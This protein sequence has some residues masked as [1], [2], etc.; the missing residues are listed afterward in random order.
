MS[1]WLVS[2]E[3]ISII[4]TWTI[5]NNLEAL[6]NKSP[7]QWFELLYNENVRSLKARYSNPQDLI[8]WDLKDY[9]FKSQ[10]HLLPSEYPNESAIAVLKLLGCWKYQ[11]CE[12]N[13]DKTSLPWKLVLSLREKIHTTIYLP[14][15]NRERL[16][17]DKSTYFD[18]LY[19]EILP[20]GYDADKWKAFLAHLESKRPASPSLTIIK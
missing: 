18:H 3:C 4:L 7:Q 20:W 9:R 10:S 11:S 5:K 19:K 6:G 16:D 8:Y 14:D 12:G 17:K 15:Y 2:N 1:A 13:Y